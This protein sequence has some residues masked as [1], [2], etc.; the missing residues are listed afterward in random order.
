[1]SLETKM[2]AYAYSIRDRKEHTMVNKLFT[3]DQTSN[4][5]ILGWR[6]KK[7]LQILKK[8]SYII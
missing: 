1:M 6:L 5:Y 4:M 3:C 2:R 7:S 8:H